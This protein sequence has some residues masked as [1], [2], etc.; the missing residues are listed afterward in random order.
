VLSFTA[1]RSYAQI[2]NAVGAFVVL[3]CVV[4]IAAR[5]VL[6]SY[7]V[8]AGRLR[9]LHATVLPVGLAAVA[10]VILRIAKVIA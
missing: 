8:A 2:S 1:H 10:V 4:L 6:R 9:L 5:E 3:L 7:G